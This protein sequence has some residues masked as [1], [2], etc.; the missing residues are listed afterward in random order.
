MNA[1]LAGS[2]LVMTL[3]PAQ[4]SSPERVKLFL[5]APPSAE[6]FTAANR[7]FDESYRD[8]RGE[9][10]KE[11]A[12]Q[13]ELEL[14]EIADEAD[15]ILEIVDRGLRDTGARTGT[16]TVIAPD[17][18]VGTSAPVRQKAV[19]ARLAVRGTEYKIDLDGRQGI[20]LK[21]TY[22]NQAKSLLRQVVD[23]VRANRSALERARENRRTH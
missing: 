20:K 11:A 23:W 10:G 19:L 14:V 4:P 12:F 13:S 5:G 1:A 7:E 15:L 18:I 21:M 17:V 16:E 22:R 8:I 9:L 2:I 6:G 3:Q